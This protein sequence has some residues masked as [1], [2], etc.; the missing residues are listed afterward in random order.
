MEYAF[1]AFPDVKL[2]DRQ[3]WQKSPTHINFYLGLPTVPELTSF[4][5]CPGLGYFCPGSY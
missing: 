5:P 3:T 2:K 4:V 1:E